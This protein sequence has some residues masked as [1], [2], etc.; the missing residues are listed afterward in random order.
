MLYAR[1]RIARRITWLRRAVMVQSPSSSSSCA[2]CTARDCFCCDVNAGEVLRV[3]A[4]KRWIERVAADVGERGA[5]A[6]LDELRR[7]TAI[8]SV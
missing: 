5:R 7:R 3:P 1:R 6:L 2:P 8:S 4:N